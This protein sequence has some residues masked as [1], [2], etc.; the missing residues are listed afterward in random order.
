MTVPR[1]QAHH[2]L[3]F[4][5][6]FSPQLSTSGSGRPI[7]TM[8]FRQ[9][10]LFRQSIFGTFFFCDPKITAFLKI[11][12]LV[13]SFFFV[14]QSVRIQ[15]NCQ[16]GCECYSDKG[17]LGPLAEAQTV[18]ARPTSYRTVSRTHW[19]LCISA[20]PPDLALPLLMFG[21]EQ[22]AS[23]EVENTGSLRVEPRLALSCRLAPPSSCS[24]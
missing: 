21:F 9:K 20:P 2:K 11:K 23:V 3:P 1:Q 18:F 15:T 7:Q 16:T 8:L 22:M 17:L 10:M 24:L 14:R 13:S 12:L 19:H 5:I 4:G 6:T